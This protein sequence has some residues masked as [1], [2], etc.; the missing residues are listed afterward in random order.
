MDA[1]TLF[2]TARCNRLLNDSRPFVLAAGFNTGTLSKLRFEPSRNRSTGTMAL[3]RKMPFQTLRR[4]RVARHSIG[5]VPSSIYRHSR[6]L[7]AA[8]VRVV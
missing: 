6:I 1:G 3:M 7:T 4:C 8:F 5:L 2:L